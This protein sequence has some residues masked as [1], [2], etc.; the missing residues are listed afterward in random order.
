M[1]FPEVGII[2]GTLKCVSG[3][4]QGDPGHPGD[5]EKA[6]GDPDVEPV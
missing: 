1:E 3:K 5:P 2:W 6:E 4:V